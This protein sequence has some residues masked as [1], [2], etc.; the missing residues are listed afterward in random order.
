MSDGFGRLL[1]LTHGWLARGHAKTAVGVLR[2][3]PERAAAVIEPEL[4]GRACGEALG[5]GGA[6]PIV[7]SVAEALPL[8]PD[9]LLVGISPAGGALPPEFEPFLDEALAAGLNVASGLHRFLGDEPRWAAAA[10]ARGCRL[11]DLRRPPRRLDIAHPH[12]ARR[13]RV[14][15]TVGTDCNVGKMTASLLL[16]RALAARGRRAHFVATGQ[17]GVLLAGGG[18]CVDALPADFVAGAVQAEIARVDAEQPAAEW[19]VVEGQG[20]LVHPAFSGVTLGLLHGAWPD[21][22]LLC[23]E[24]GRAVTSHTDAW[25][26]PGPDEQRRWIEAA[27]AW[28]HPAPVVGMALRTEKLDEETALT[29][30]KN[31]AYEIGLPVAD[32]LRFGAEPLAAA[33]DALADVREGGA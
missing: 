31:A 14:L 5:F 26:L 3:Q 19:I 24:A 21:A 20:S 16:V 17:T 4:A 25:P 18:I 15:L 7:A 12:P 29:A 33:L 2:F 22:V 27:A 32:P 28:L 10:A 23:H 6:T 30:C 13:A 9:A 1:L 11:W 8:A